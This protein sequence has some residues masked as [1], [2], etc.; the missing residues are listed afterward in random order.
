MVAMRAVVFM[1]L[2]DESLTVLDEELA[3]FR[4]QTLTRHRDRVCGP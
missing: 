4:R 2:L 3:P 1:T